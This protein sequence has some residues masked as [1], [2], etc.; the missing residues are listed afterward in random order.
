[1]SKTLGV[2]D[3]ERSVSLAMVDQALSSHVEVNG[4]TLRV[5]EWKPETTQSLP[6]VVLVHGLASNALLWQGAAGALAARGHRVFAIDQRGHGQSSKP[7]SG[8]DMSTVTSDL[9]AFLEHLSSG[10]VHRPVVAGQSWGGNIVIELAH[11]HPE[12]TRGVVAVDGGFLELGVHFPDWNDCAT[13]LKPPNLLGTPATRMREYMRSAHA[14]W[15]E[16]GID[17]QMGNFEV[18]EDGT[19]RPWL[20]LDRHLQVLRGLWEH[21]PITLFPFI[22][23]PVMFVPADSNHSIF[24]TTKRQSVERAIQALSRGRVEWF[25]G[26]DHDLHAQHPERFADVVSNAISE[27]FFA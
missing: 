5:L 10:G 4:V 13:A 24:S 25:H 27:G 6:A 20:S 17:G 19:I 11:R 15:P 16:S 21:Q 2:I 26:A 22:T 12:L 9:A 1:M 3:I 14:D 8:Y 23:V 7:E 18:L